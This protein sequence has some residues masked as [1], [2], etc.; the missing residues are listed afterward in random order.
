MSWKRVGTV[1]TLTNNQLCYTDGTNVICDS[2]APTNL[3]GNIG[4]GSTNPVNLLDIGTSGGIH[5]GPGI[6]T[7]TNYALYNNGGV[8][9]WN[10]T[11][12]GAG[13]TYPSGAGIAVSTGSAWGTSISPGTGV[14]TALANAT[15][16]TGG[17]VTFNGALGTPT[18]GTLTNAT[19]LPLGGLTSQAANISCGHDIGERSIGFVDAV[20]LG[21]LERSWL[22]DR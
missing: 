3:S 17:L 19:G 2:T 12:L 22:D 10:G 7:N 15:N 1:T 4:I 20:M 13:M 11:A 18:S 14:S 9:T 5:I 8:L 21:S 16:A 6:P